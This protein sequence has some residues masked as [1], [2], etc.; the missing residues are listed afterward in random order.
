[1][2]IENRFTVSLP[3]EDA[4]K[5]LLDVEGIAPCMPGAEIEDVIEDGFA[6]SVRVKLGAIL[7]TFK[8][9]V[10]FKEVDEDTHRIVLHASGRETKGQGNATAD[11]TAVLAASDGGTAVAIDSDIRITGRIVQ[12]GRGVILD[13]SAKLIQQFVDCLE[14]KLATGSL[15]PD[16]PPA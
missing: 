9:T 7:A 1:V 12:F 15:V 11:V 6:G 5:V 4:W 10:V 14:D 3:V 2:R 13:V 16:G 8:G